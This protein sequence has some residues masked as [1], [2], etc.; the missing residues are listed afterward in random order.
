M[1]RHDADT[2]AELFNWSADVMF[3]PAG[4]GSCDVCSEPHQPLVGVVPDVVTPPEPKMVCCSC[5]SETD[6]WNLFGEAILEHIE[7]PAHEEVDPGYGAW[8]D[9]DLPE[10]WPGYAPNYEPWDELLIRF[11]CEETEVPA[12]RS[13][14]E[15][16]T[17]PA[18]H[19][20]HNEQTLVVNGI[21][22]EYD[23]YV[24]VD[25]DGWEEDETIAE[26]E[27]IERMKATGGKTYDDIKD[28]RI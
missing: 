3:Y 24:P 6:S 25:V 27:H 17:V 12:S 1:V 21:E 9:F 14:F 28:E 5:L 16:K 19:I 23:G 7:P 8:V 18:I 4:S 10:E 11:D 2:L 13:P 15:T 26:R 20:G 22:Y